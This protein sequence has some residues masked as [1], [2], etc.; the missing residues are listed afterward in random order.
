[1]PT[2]HFYPDLTYEQIK[3]IEKKYNTPDR[4]FLINRA[5]DYICKII[6]KSKSSQNKFLF[7]CGPGSNGLDGMFTA[8]KL[9]SLG[10]DIKIFYTKKNISCLDK[11]ELKKYL[12]TNFSPNDFD[13]IVDCIYGY[14][15]NRNLDEEQIDLVKKI[16]LSK[17]FIF[18]IDVPSGLS[19]AT[20]RMC[21]ICVKSNVLISLLTYKRGLFTCSGRDAWDK[22]Y[23]TNLID[24]K[25]ISKNY[26]ISAD[27]N[28][29][30][31]S[32]SKN[33]RNKESFS[34]HKKSKGVSCIVSG[35]QPYH[36][37]MLLSV[38][39]L[40]KLGCQY[41]YVYTDKEYALSL[42]MIIPEVISNSFSLADFKN[43]FK[44]FN[45][46]L[47]GP[48]TDKITK[49]YLDYISENL[50]LINSLVVDAGALK[51]L[52]K[53]F[54]YSNKLIITPHPGEAAELLNMHKKDIQNNRY[55]AAKML[56][57]MFDCI[58]VLKGSGTIIYDGNS[59]FTCMD[60]NYRM[61]VAGMGDTLA[62]ILVY[63]LSLCS[64]TLDACIKAVTFHSYSADYLMKVM[65]EEKFMPSMIPEVYNKLV[66]S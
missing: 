25:L 43:R 11:F 14:G 49:K 34:Q 52:K 3:N 48:G 12:I 29:G 44:K 2:V 16:N 45:N 64:N 40:M 9:A 7:I 21:P 13:C 20:G 27:D 5:S 4:D 51:F 1:M 35:E 26:L 53:G 6:T 58:V 19:P 39:A 23:C 62:G 31:F 30:T 60:G 54:S 33:Y 65:K 18:S 24:E 55:K 50:D 57:E 37:A 32:L 36:G 22:I 17:A 8:H 56:N 41:L 63:E 59:F 28:F 15:F 47:I 10:Y 46:I 66:N 42:P 61:A 38:T